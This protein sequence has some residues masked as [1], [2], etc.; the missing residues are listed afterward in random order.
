[1]D[2]KLSGSE[3]SCESLLDLHVRPDPSRKEHKG[4]SDRKVK[5][6]PKVGR[7]FEQESRRINGRIWKNDLHVNGRSCHINCSPTALV[8][9][10]D[11]ICQKKEWL[12]DQTRRLSGM[13][14]TFHC[15]VIC[16]E[17]L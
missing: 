7:K 14:M 12:G 10:L 5:L 6:E 13:F 4:G 8:R 15:L 2:P 9:V 3:L 1:M 17:F 11:V 16:H